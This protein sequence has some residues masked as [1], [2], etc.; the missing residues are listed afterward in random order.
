MSNAD[1]TLELV[2]VAITEA[3]DRLTRQL[4]PGHARTLFAALEIPITGAQES[5]L[6]QG[7]L[8]S[9]IGGLRDAVQRAAE[10]S[11]AIE[12]EDVGK[13]MS[14][15]LGLI[16]KLAD[17]IA[18][19]EALDSLQGLDVDPPTL[20]K[21]PERMFNYA[22]VEYLHQFRGVNETLELLGILER[23]QHNGGSPDPL[24]VPYET[25]TFKL[26]RLGQWLKS[27]A[28]VLKTL[29]GWGNP[30]FNHSKLLEHLERL[31][32]SRGAPVLLDTSGPVPKLDV[33]D[34][35]LEPVAAGAKEG[36]AIR[37]KADQAAAEHVWS[38]ED[39][40]ARLA[41]DLSL[42]NLTELV[43]TP[44]DGV[45]IVPPA[46]GT[47]DGAIELKIAADRTQ[48]AEPYVL[49]GQPGGSRLTLRRFEFT[50]G[51]EFEWDA[52]TSEASG[53]LHVGGG[54]AGG[55]LVIALDQADGFLGKILSGVH[56]ESQFDL[57][58]TA[59]SKHGITFT[60]SSALEIKLPLHLALG[61]VELD[62]LTFS[63]GVKGNQFPTSIGADIK[64]ALG[65]LEAVV[66]D[67]G[68]KID[69]SLKDDR[70]GNAGP[71]DLSLGFKPPKGVGLSLD[72]GVAKGG[73]YLF[74]DFDREEYAGALEI[75]VLELVT[76]KAVGLITTKMPDGSKGFSL[77]ILISAEFTPIQL[78]FGFTLNGVG[79]LFGYN[80]RMMLDALRGGIRTG[81]I[82]SVLFPKDVVKN[83]PKIISD[84]KSFFP[85][86][87]G[88]FV[89]GPMAKIGWGTPTL[90]TLTLGLFIEIPGNVAI[91]GILAL[92]L[93]DEAAAL[94]VIKVAFIGTLDFDKKMFAFDASLYESRILFI[95]LEGDM[96][97][98]LTWGD[99]PQ[100]LLS[101]G[102][103]HPTYEPPP[104]AL[105]SLRRI[106]YSI[107][108][109][110]WAR[111]RMESYFAITS[112]TVQFGSRS[113]AFFG[114]DD[115]NVS[116][117]LG[118][119]VLLQFS[120]FYFVAGVSGGFCLEV[121]GLDVLTIHLKASLEGPS[122][123]RIKGRGS[124]S[125][126]FWD[127]EVD[128]D[129]TWGEKKNTALPGIDVMQLFA[130]E[131][132]KDANWRAL[133][134]KSKNL[135]VSLRKLEP[136]PLVLHPAGKLVM[137][138]RAV[139]LGFTLD[140]VGNR[141]PEDVHRVE[142]TAATTGSTVHGLSPVTEQFAPGQFQTM[143]DAEK[144]SRPSYEPMNGG[145]VIEI[146][147]GALKSGKKTVRT[148]AYETTIID[149]APAKPP[150]NALQLIPGALFHTLL[151]GAS[152]GRSQLSHRKK[153]QMQ[154]HAEKVAVAAEGYTVASTQDNTPHGGAASFTSH[155]MANDHM[156]QALAGD[157]AL[158][159][160][161]HV[162]PNY[163]V[164]A[165]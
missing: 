118:Y 18:A 43:L 146:G 99:N 157:P 140:R 36:L 86:H 25:S 16:A 135:L 34:F 63:V 23:Q 149:K 151:G 62:A 160:S 84:L 103:F 154:P 59:S 142:I 82:N 48:A 78:G 98:R 124:V 130:G 117:H 64:A 143:T 112:N 101:V 73:G 107:L 87:D 137:S 22:I 96:A 57:G 2:L 44:D 115:F 65:P 152:V 17:V 121:F 132:G 113:E 56:V 94:I 134:P 1:G 72:A 133:A 45:R 70:S 161:L 141:Q 35:E 8:K 39:W 85:A 47:Y 33:V 79:G 105:P 104:L 42:P 109:T 7:P 138:Q 11:D 14:A 91:A 102:G 159:G 32:A 119:D 5:A 40:S 76:V 20:A 6:L 100:F 90:I 111:I 4:A 12:D 106:T 148:I 53:E 126:L 158:K 144:L 50:A 93:P 29:Y 89:V 75:A 54:L 67:I 52:G 69:L 125:I 66:E 97:V 9:L 153:S 114:F 139:P 162:I 19:L 165:S 129:E 46:P 128:F 108:D 61:P 15:G 150:N 156:K 147:D 77:L 163:E 31:L 24:D 37:L 145:V 81:A 164:K 136:G 131:V 51:A 155:A 120:P 49:L 3:L 71:L 127:I 92:N 116:G 88:K 27:P 26:E 123:W 30:T 41:V 95:T 68:L 110:S 55:E 83:A 10:L 122:P 74:F 28:N 80:R 13:T 21:L 60:G 58:F 38:S